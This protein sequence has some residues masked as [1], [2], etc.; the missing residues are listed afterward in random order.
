VYGFVRF[1]FRDAARFEKYGDV[2]FFRTT[3]ED[4]FASYYD[5]FRFRERLVRLDR[6]E[7]I[8]LYFVMAVGDHHG[9]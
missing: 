7:L 6:G 1:T 4:F 2:R 9:F 8:T 5:C 3:R